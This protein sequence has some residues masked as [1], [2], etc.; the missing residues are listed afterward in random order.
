MTTLTHLLTT[1]FANLY[2]FFFLSRPQGT[3]KS[4]ITILKIFKSTDGPSES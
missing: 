3:A 4:L 1:Q 2:L